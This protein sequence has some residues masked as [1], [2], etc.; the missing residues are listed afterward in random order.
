MLILTLV[1]LLGL[2][3]SI[4]VVVGVQSPISLLIFGIA[5]WQAW[6]MNRTAEPP[7]TGPYRFLR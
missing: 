1:L 6:M 7:V 5:L 4:P 3:Y 2:V